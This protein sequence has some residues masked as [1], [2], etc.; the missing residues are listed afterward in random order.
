MIVLVY[1]YEGSGPTHWQ[2][3][4][5]AQLRERG[6]PY[7]FPELP[8]PNAPD[9]EAWLAALGAAVADSPSPV[10]FVTHSLG[11]W[12][13]DH[14]LARHGAAGIA[15]AL[16]VCPPSAELDFPPIA[17]FLP[18]PRDP[19]AWAP[20]AGRSLLLGSDDDPY[21]T[22]DEFRALSARLGMP[23]ELVKGGAHLNTASGFGPFP[24]VLEWVL[25]SV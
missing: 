23:F 7:R 25:S 12:C 11:G 16:L 20:I 3:W 14:Y 17:S 10:R 1:G 8:S 2:H 18:P 5:A 13:V 22:P 9:R 24:R 4:L 19:R 6:I 15:G 21:S